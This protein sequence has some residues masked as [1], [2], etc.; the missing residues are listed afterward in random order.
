MLSTK[1]EARVTQLQT[2]K[3]LINDVEN[4]DVYQSV[5]KG[6]IGRPDVSWSI[7]SISHKLNEM[8]NTFI[9][10]LITMLIGLLLLIGMP[11]CGADNYRI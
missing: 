4:D 8:L 6:A 1:P 11:F 9:I 3:D 5:T 7:S 2:L 10:I